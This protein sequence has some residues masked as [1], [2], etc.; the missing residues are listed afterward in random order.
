M[1][2]NSWEESC[3]L[4]KLLLVLLGAIP[5]AAYATLGENDSSIVQD[6]QVLA[7]TSSLVV[8]KQLNTQKSANEKY[9][10]SLIK[11]S[12]DITIKEFSAN[13]KVFAVVWNGVHN[14]DLQQLFGAY[15][16]SFKTSK[17][18]YNSLTYREINDADLVVKTY[19]VVGD[20]HGFAY[21]PS[22]LPLGVKPSD[23]NK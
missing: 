19:G 8:T 2:L 4:K 12:D 20:F 14:P 5:L 9:T 11:A 13:G 17:P 10:V 21:I 18:S 1:P 22:L 3:I 16:T 23:L 7:S 15:F 6:N